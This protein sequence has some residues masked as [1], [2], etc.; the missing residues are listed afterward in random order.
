MFLTDTNLMSDNRLECLSNLKKVSNVDV[1]LITSE[2]INDYILK[3]YPLHESY[4]YLSSVHKSDYLRTYFMNFYGGGYSD[5]KKTTG[6]WKDA[7]KDI[8]N[9]DKYINGYKE[10]EGGVAYK[11]LKDKYKELIGCG[12]FISKPNSK[13]T[14]EWYNEMISLLDKKLDKLKKSS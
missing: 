4:K 8:N 1:I 10:I 13:L 14:N 7:F 3:E 2:N 6:S 9:S 5:I 12:S 11:P